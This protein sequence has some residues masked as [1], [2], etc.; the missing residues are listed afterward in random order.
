MLV[1]VDQNQLRT[2]VSETVDTIYLSHPHPHGQYQGLGSTPERP[3][4]SLNR[5]SSAIAGLQFC[6]LTAFST[7]DLPYA[8]TQGINE[9]VKNWNLSCFKSPDYL[10]FFNCSIWLYKFE[11]AYKTLLRKKKY[12]VLI[13]LHMRCNI[14][15]LWF[16]VHHWK[17][18]ILNFVVFS[19]Y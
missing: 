16:T 17:R 8:A 6:N 13:K 5:C 15:T 3:V 2:M 19:V 10:E 7:R 18:K 14:N 4:N 1:A 9:N 11:N 12:S